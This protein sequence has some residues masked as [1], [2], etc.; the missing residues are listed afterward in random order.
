MFLAVALLCFL[1]SQGG[2]VG[3]SQKETTAPRR[4]T[5]S[6]KWRVD[7][8]ASIGGPE[9]P[10]VWGRK[11][12][13]KGRPKT[14][15][16]FTDNDTVVA[17]FVTSKAKVNP[18]LSSRDTS[19]ESLPLR[20]RA[21]FLNTAT[22]SI[23]ATPEWPSQSRSA[24]IVAV[25]NGRFVTQTGNDVTLYGPDLRALKNLALPS[26]EKGD[27][28]ADPSPT[29]KTILFL[30]HALRTVN[31]ITTDPWLWVETDTLKVLHSGEVTQNGEVAISDENMVRITCEWIYDCGPKI[32]MRGPSTEWKTIARASRHEY[33][34]FIN[35]GMMFLSGDSPRLLRVDG[36]VLLTQGEPSGRAFAA[37][38]GHRF[39]VPSCQMEGKIATLDI[40]GHCVLKAVLVYDISPTRQSYTLEIKGPRIKGEMVF[41]I[42][43]D[44]T[45]FAVLNNEVIQ[46][47]QLPPLQ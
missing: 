23:S 8:R 18:K 31:G 5:V 40:S 2:S 6:P 10:I 19:D 30:P 25:H 4:E 33:P 9:L 1:T 16:W 24:G 3:P 12:E 11:K 42:S 21:A 29:G 34:R 13:Y 41:A 46:V 15:L 20:L 26:S 44:G 39:V 45:E 38:D 7:L 47:F 17:T 22:G 32:E 37:A 14:S 43:P 36:E 28:R 35:Q 27:W